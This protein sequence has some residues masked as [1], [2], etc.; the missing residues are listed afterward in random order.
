[1]RVCGISAHASTL[2]PS[3]AH[4]SADLAVSIVAFIAVWILMLVI[5]RR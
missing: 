5:I 2:A 3:P 4:V 1:V